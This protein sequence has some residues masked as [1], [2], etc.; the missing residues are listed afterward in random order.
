MYTLKGT[1]I[2]DE[3]LNG[4]VLSNDNREVVIENGLYL[5]KSKLHIFALKS[6]FYST[7]D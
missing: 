5:N 2:P 7:Y 3:I 6:V 1:I 4:S